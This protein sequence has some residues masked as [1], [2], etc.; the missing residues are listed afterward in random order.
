MTEPE[1]QWGPTETNNLLVRMIC[2]LPTK[3]QSP[4]NRK[5]SAKIMLTQKVTYI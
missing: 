2:K 5:T 3:M 1:K 4:T